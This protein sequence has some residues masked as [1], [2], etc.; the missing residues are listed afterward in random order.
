VWAATVGPFY[1][2]PVGSLGGAA[3][4]G[5]LGRNSSPATLSP[6]AERIVEV[7]QPPYPPRAV[8]RLGA[9]AGAAE[10]ALIGAVHGQVMGAVLGAYLGLGVGMASAAWAWKTRH[11]IP[12]FAVRLLLGAAA[13]SVGCLLLG[14]LIRLLALDQAVLLVAAVI[15]AGSL[16]YLAASVVFRLMA[17]RAKGPEGDYD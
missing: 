9:V 2:I 4:G 15:A 12:L 6:L 8:L 7:F 10:G 3:L 11:H 5:L 1:V 17:A 16:A 14:F 13:E